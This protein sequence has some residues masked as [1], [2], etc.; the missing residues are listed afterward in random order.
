[1]NILHYLPG[2]PPV[3][4]GGMII[5]ALDLAEEECKTDKV[6]LLIPGPI[7]ISTSR[8]NHVSIK[9]KSKWKGIPVYQIRNPLPI[10]MANGILDVTWFTLSCKTQVYYDFLKR[11]SLDVIHVH[12]LMGIHKEFFQAANSLKIQLVYTTHDYFGICPKA[13]LYH[14]REIC[15]SPG[16]CCGECSRYAFSEKRLLIEQSKLYAMYRNNQRMIKILQGDLLKRMMKNIR[17]QN[18]VQK[19]EQEKAE[20]GKRMAVPL[21]TAEDYEGLLQYY[22]NIFQHISFFHF[23]SSL[24]KVVFETHLG[25]LPG[26]V[27]PVTNK[28]VQDNRTLRQLDNKLRIGFLGGDSPYKGLRRLRKVLQE[29]YTA[30]MMNM[31]LHIYGSLERETCPFCIYHD[32]Y[33]NKDKEKVFANMDVLAVPSS[34]QETFGMVV[35]EAL[36]YGIPIVMTEKVGAK[37][38]VVQG[39]YGKIIED[40]DKAL[41]KIFEEIYRNR[42]L[43]IKWSTNIVK[44]NLDFDYTLHVKK[45]KQIYNN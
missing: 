7:S 34:W 29:L 9:K 41:K 21:V 23:N 22:R 45:I 30:G 11:L 33:G 16:E 35:L 10:P 24:A 38:L 8:R 42:D 12:S 19:E 32:K 14:H 13:D 25:K 40:N 26:Q 1:M 17:S 43:L 18:P 3:R 31:E 36:S 28:G 39:T 5:Y 27:I 44:A 37:D 15:M 6:A 4:G 2:L 20:G